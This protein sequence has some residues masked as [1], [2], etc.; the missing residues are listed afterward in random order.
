MVQSWWAVGWDLRG[1]RM[2]Q[3]PTTRSSA[4]ELTFQRDVGVHKHNS[5]RTLSA[6]LPGHKQSRTEFTI[7][8]E[9]R[10][11]PE[12]FLSTNSLGKTSESRSSVMRNKKLLWWITK[13]IVSFNHKYICLPL[14][15]EFLKQNNCYAILL[16]V[17]FYLTNIAVFSTSFKKKKKSSPNG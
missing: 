16:G 13:G 1:K 2:T 15:F 3:A 10:G 7:K 6:R 8:N 11:F 12:K 4:P 9:S 17:I 5:T 14:S